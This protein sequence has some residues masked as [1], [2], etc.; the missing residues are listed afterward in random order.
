VAAGAG[1]LAVV[2]LILVAALAVVA[3]LLVAD[4]RRIVGL[5]S[6]FLPR[7]ADSGA[8]AEPD[9]VMLGSVHLRR[10][11][12]Q[13]ARLHHGGAARR[14]MADYQFAATELALACD[15][16]RRGLMPP[17]LFARRRQDMLGL[18]RAAVTVFRERRPPMPNP[19]WAPHGGSIFVPSVS[20]QPG[21]TGP[22]RFAG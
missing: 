6:G 22:D 12:R 15:R 2:Y 16:Q 5:I 9:V 21:G 11:A 20:E 7:F 3:A 13:W 1:R 14:A 19:P 17:S 10:L 4:R 18:M 8:L